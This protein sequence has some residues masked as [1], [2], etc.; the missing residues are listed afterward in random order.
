MMLSTHIHMLWQKHHESCDPTAENGY[1]C[2]KTFY[3]DKESEFYVAD[4]E[5]FWIILNHAVAQEEHGDERAAIEVQGSMQ[6]HDGTV[7]LVPGI[8]EKCEQSWWRFRPIPCQRLEVMGQDEGFS[9]RSGDHFKLQTLLSAA[10]LDLDKVSVRTNRTYR[11][12]GVA[13]RVDIEYYNTRSFNLLQQDRRIAYRYKVALDPITSFRIDEIRPDTHLKG[14]LS[15]ERLQ[16]RKHGVYLRINVSGK[17]GYFSL[18]ELLIQAAA[19][20]ALLAAC[21]ML[22]SWLATQPFFV[23]EVRADACKEKIREVVGPGIDEVEFGVLG[24]VEKQIFKR[25]GQEE[26]D[27]RNAFLC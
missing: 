15:K 18:H 3:T 9:D 17:F 2:G 12:S 25:M 16:V 8:E 4:I 6:H 19:R 20:M 22:V 24:R 10:G 27:E 7:R 13:L 23:G 1:S 21:D 5:S 14:A 11:N 26:A